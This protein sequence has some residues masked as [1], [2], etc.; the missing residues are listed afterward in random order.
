MEKITIE[1]GLGSCGIAAGGLEVIEAFKNELTPLNIDYRITEKGCI[2]Q[3]YDEVLVKI[4]KNGEI[5]NYSKITPEKV[6]KIVKNHIVD[7]NP[8]KGY[9]SREDGFFEKQERISLR[10]VGRILATDIDEYIKNDGYEGLKKALNMAPENIIREVEL[11]GLRGRGGGGFPTGT[12][13]GFARSS[14]G[15][16]KYIICNG[17]EGD[18]GAFMDRSIMEGDPHSVIEGMIIAGIAIGAASG[19]VYVRAEYPLA[20]KNLKIAVKNARERGFL[21]KN[22]LDSSFSFD[23]YI[24][25]GAGA[26]VCGEE[27]ALIASVEGER[28]MPRMR[29]PYPAVSG[30]LKKPTNINNVETY[31]NIPYILYK[32][33][34]AYSKFGFDRSRGTKVFALAGKVKRVGLV[35]VPMGITLREVI[36][37]IGGGMSKSKKFKAA[38]LG[39][40]SGG[41]VPESLLDTV[42]GYETIIETGAIMGS[43][44]LVVMDETTCMVDIARFFLKFTQDESCGKCTFC[45]IGTKRMMELLN[46]ICDGDGTMEDIDQLEELAQNIKK[47][48][49]CGLGQTAPNPVVT[50]LKYF[51]HEYISH[52]KDKHCPAGK[53]KTL[54]TFVVDE[55]TC[56]GCHAC[57]RVCPVEAIKGEPK[58]MHFIEQDKCVKCGQCLEICRFDSILVKGRNA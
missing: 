27:T 57:V 36:F 58:K 52:V 30:Y 56:T 15:N 46:K 42:V 6:N 53:C 41:C 55:K 26:F 25:E 32:G 28:G 44:G 38:Q 19:L 17:D 9:L 34:E 21:G 40:P 23:V 7:G 12:K 5:I 33:S 22:I 13:W 47:L 16:E 49:L 20:V 45:R 11:S 4:Y 39:G 48:S 31:S 43:G 37:D 10:N 8:V 54:S 29:P 1:V 24:K 3:C 2:G 50:T 18:P 51:R 35:E 14:K